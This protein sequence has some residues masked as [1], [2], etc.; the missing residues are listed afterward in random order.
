MGRQA[1]AAALGC[2]Y[3]NAGT[4]EFIVSADDPSNFFF[5]EMNTRLQVEHPVT[6][7]VYRLDLVECQLRIAVG[8]ALGLRQDEL[9]PLGHAVEARVYAED[10]GKGFLPT[11]GHLYSVRDPQGQGIRVDSGVSSGR[12]V[13]SDY[14]PMI[15]K[16]I[17]FGADRAE[18]L[19]R[20]DRALAETETIGVVSNVAFLRRLIRHP[21]VRAGRLDTGLVDRT[22]EE[23]APPASADRALVVAAVWASQCASRGDGPWTQL[24][25]WRHGH[26]APSATDFEVDGRRH[27][28]EVLAPTGVDGQ[29]AVVLDE[30]P[31][32]SARLGRVDETSP[33]G[34]I[35]L[36]VALDELR[37]SATL[38][39]KQLFCYVV[40]DG[41]A[42]VLRRHDRLPRG[43]AD[44][45]VGL[46]DGVVRSPM[47][48]LVIGLHVSVGDVVR[49]GHA[50]ATVEAMKMEHT[51]HARTA[52][53][54]L[55]IS[56][57]VGT[58]VAIGDTLIVIEP[59]QSPDQ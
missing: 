37:F 53:V 26:R 13:V 35:R 55:S 19:R 11:G 56:V 52:G 43:I 3:V 42:W 10:P 59:A 40:I 4:V 44:S 54:V 21:D 2:G 29:W 41:E 34:V 36:D 39:D 28:V 48:G 31:P 12:V 49:V 17:A 15:A 32:F 25:G 22:V 27:R 18:A 30:R 6:E 20:L 23:L 1:I 33:D 57:G 5:M 46:G 16:V 45:A 58:Q 14:D 9:V 47:P 50:V 51:L 7:M 38:L 8:E 24:A